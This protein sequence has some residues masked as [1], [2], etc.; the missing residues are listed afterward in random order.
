MNSVK[1]FF[2]EYWTLGREKGMMKMAKNAGSALWFG[3]FGRHG[4]AV[5]DSSFV[6]RLKEYPNM[7]DFLNI[8]EI[9][10]SY[11]F[12]DQKMRARLLMATCKRFKRSMAAEYSEEQRARRC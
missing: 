11:V 7:S 9:Y 4:R 10:G 6:F 8:P 1:E 2:A 5:C 3:R 12:G